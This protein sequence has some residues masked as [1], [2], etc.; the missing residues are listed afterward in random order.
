MNLLVKTMI[1]ILLTSNAY[2]QTVNDVLE[3]G[4]HVKS[5]SDIYFKLENSG[6]IIYGYNLKKNSSKIKIDYEFNTD[7]VLFLTSDNNTEVFIHPLNPLNFTVSTAAKLIQDPISKAEADALKSI[8]ELLTEANIKELAN[9]S[10]EENKSLQ[11]KDL[12]IGEVKSDLASDNSEIK[13][14]NQIFGLLKKLTFEDKTTT[15]NNLTLAI[16][17]TCT[18]RTHLDK[19][20]TAIKLLEE[21]AKAFG[22]G[23]KKNEIIL[24]RYIYLDYVSSLQ[25]AYNARLKQYKN[26]KEAIILVQEMIDNSS[27]SDNSDHWQYKLPPI[28]VTN[29]KNI[30][31]TV[32]IDSNAWN[33]NE[34]GVLVKKSGGKTIS[35]VIVVRKFQLLVPEVS[36]GTYYTF[37]KYKVYGTVNDSITGQQY[38]AEPTFNIL[39]RFNVS[40]MLNYNFYIPNT[41][42]RPL[43][44]FGGGIQSG[45][46][47]L[48]AGGGLRIG[49]SNAFSITGGVA[50]TWVR[51]LE[52]LKI[53]DPVSGTAELE[54]DLKYEF[55]FPLKGYIGIQYNF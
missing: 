42:V 14:I 2:S 15:I 46:P 7:S 1:C 29:G 35:R 10:S 31:Y 26:L 4:N 3:K 23:T 34:E 21:D 49:N 37:F 52:T 48:M 18:I 5:G 13:K 28:S 16:K 19:I 55:T 38:V 32:T 6:Q 50:M 30:I 33:L 11:D 22:K 40:V 41:S 45:I 53:G 36:V 39:K 24:L 12:K 44:Q 9:A 51:E 17:D 20:N 47:V 27:D 54:K 8:R 25:N 43:I